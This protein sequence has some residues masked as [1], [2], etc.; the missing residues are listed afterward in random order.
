MTQNSLKEITKLIASLV[1]SNNTIALLRQQWEELEQRINQVEASI[2]SI[3]QNISRQIAS[4]EFDVD[5][6]RLLTCGGKTYVWTI[7]DDNFVNYM[8]VD[9]TASSYE[10][11][12]TDD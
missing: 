12:K 8:E 4:L 5:K 9:M 2:S 7:N 3:Q 6:A 10:E 1:K 11:V